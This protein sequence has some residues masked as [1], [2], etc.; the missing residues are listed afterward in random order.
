MP[1][2]TEEKVKMFSPNTGEYHD[3]LAKLD[4]GTDENWIS[5]ATLDLLKLKSRVVASAE[6]LTFN[7]KTFESNQEV[8]IIW[9]GFGSTITRETSFRVVANAPFKVVIGKNYL[10]KEG[11]VTI[12]RSN[13][14]FILVKKDNK[15]G[16]LGSSPFKLFG[17]NNVLAEAMDVQE[18]R[19]RANAESAEL[20]HR[21]KEVKAGKLASRS[22]TKRGSN[23]GSGG[24]K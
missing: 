5:Q 8:S 22:G 16:E 21:Q 4:T 9:W 15:E 3:L 18:N 14:A 24:P 2:P 17:D 19:T 6:F 7:H 1:D 13:G 10:L 20:A 23:S 12:K 11:I